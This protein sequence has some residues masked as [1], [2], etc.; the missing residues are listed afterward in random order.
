[1]VVKRRSRKTGNTR[2][3]LN[4]SSRRTIKRVRKKK[5]S[6]KKKRVG[7][8]GTV[9][10]MNLEEF[11][12]LP[13]EVRQ[14]I[15][16]TKSKDGNIFKSLEKDEF[17]DMP[18]EVRQNMIKSH[19][20]KYNSEAAGS[21]AYPFVEY[22]NPG[23]STVYGMNL[24]EFKSLP[25]EVRQKILKTKGKGGNI[26]KSLEKGEIKSMPK[27]VRQNMIKTHHDEYNAEARAQ[28]GTTNP[29]NMLEE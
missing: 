24:E 17:K 14:K 27:E 20:D 12:S 16:K 3:R 6:R 18:K 2:K 5:Y 21:S 23:G 25:K 29:F 22:N 10:G 7:G 8:A 28:G 1:M 15:L 19:Y 13:K 9:Y 4:K 11:K 26:F